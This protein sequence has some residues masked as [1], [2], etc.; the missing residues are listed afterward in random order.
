[1]RV[2]PMPVA[3][4][5]VADDGQTMFLD[6]AVRERDLIHKLIQVGVQYLQE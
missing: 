3:V 1:M 5:S 6:V 2:Q 4:L